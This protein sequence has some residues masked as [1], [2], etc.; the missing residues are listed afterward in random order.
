MRLSFKT[1]DILGNRVILSPPFH[2][3]STNKKK[4][5]PKIKTQTI[6]FSESSNHRINVTVCVNI[7]MLFS[8]I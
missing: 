1:G 6:H 5:K 2:S 8:V 3:P 7:I 4:K